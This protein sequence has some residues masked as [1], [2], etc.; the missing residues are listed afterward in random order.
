MR[1]LP[2]RTG[3]SLIAAR[4]STEPRGRITLNV[5]EPPADAPI[6]IRLRFVALIAAFALLLGGYGTYVAFFRPVPAFDGATDP[7]HVTAVKALIAGLPAP[8]GSTLDPYGTWCDAAAAACWTS[9]TQQ[10]KALVSELSKALVAKG[11]KV[12]SH[13]CFK[14]EDP[15]VQSDGHDDAC[16]AVLDYRGSRIELTASNRGQS[17]NGGRTFLRVDS[18]LV[19]PSGNSNSSAALGP[20]ADVNPLPTAWTTGVTCYWP[21]KDG[22]HQYG[23]PRGAPPLI[24]LPLAQVC[25]GVRASLRGRFFFGIDEDKPAT[26]SRHAYCE[27]VASLH[28]SLGGRD[29]ELVIARA[30]SVDP[31]STTLTFNVAPV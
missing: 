4:A 9:T 1:L 6:M 24:A 21:R 14:S 23:T 30:T 16:A 31:T 17:D 2:V 11:T 27:I 12:H 22:C 28:R 7:A 13:Q 15:V 25:A 20:W 26:A 19:T 5:R 10:P 3:N 8:A 18:P 29:A